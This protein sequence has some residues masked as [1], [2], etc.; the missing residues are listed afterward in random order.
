[1]T[2][3]HVFYLRL[4]STGFETRLILPIGT[5]HSRQA[6]NLKLSQGYQFELTVLIIL[7]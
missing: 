5:E 7:S 6:E 3:Q 2:R 4:V 1:M